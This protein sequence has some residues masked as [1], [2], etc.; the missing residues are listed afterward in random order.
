MGPE[1][2]RRTL[3]DA[4]QHV[5][6]EDDPA[7]VA[8]VLTR[9]AEVGFKVPEV[10][11]VVN[12][13][14]TKVL[15]PAGEGTVPVL[16]A[17]GLL[18]SW[19]VRGHGW[20]LFRA[21]QLLQACAGPLLARLQEVMAAYEGQCEADGVEPVPPMTPRYFVGGNVVDFDNSGWMDAIHAASPKPEPVQ[22]ASA[23]TSP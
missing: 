10:A 3:A 14:G 5:A 8:R 21:P 17:Q 16:L 19:A 13:G 7:V 18:R 12:P 4:W 2:W 9:A 11:P 6:G 20:V 15:W 1:A 22:R 23:R